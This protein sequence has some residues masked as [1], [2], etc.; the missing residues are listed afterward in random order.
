MIVFL[1]LITGGKT[2]AEEKKNKIMIHRAP[3]GYESILV[4][5]ATFTMG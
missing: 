2:L 3:Y 5:P 4:K 1:A